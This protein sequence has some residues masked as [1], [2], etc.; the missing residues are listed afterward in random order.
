[1]TNLNILFEKFLDEAVYSLRLREETIKGYKAAYELLIKIMPHITMPQHITEENMI[2]FF[3]LLNSRE[4]I[5]GRNTVKKGIRRSTVA[6][7]RSK[8]N[9]FFKWL[10]RK[11]YISLNPFDEMEYPRVE[12]NN[13]QYLEKE[14]IEALFNYINYYSEYNN[15]LRKRNLAIISLALYSGL[16][17]GEVLNLKLADIDFIRKTIYVCG[18]TSKSKT[19]RYVLM[20]KELAS[21]LSD[22]INERTQ[23]GYKNEY[24]IVSAIKDTKFTAHGFKHFIAK[25]NQ[26]SG[27]KFHFHQ[28]RH[29]F[30]VNCIKNGFDISELQPQMGHKDIRMTGTYLRK[31][32]TDRMRGNIE[33]LR[34]GNW[35]FSPAQFL[36]YI[37]K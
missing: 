5:V 6:T 37:G 1:M 19:D 36:N 14:K 24:F 33:G 18:E 27:V 35:C 15:F 3:K 23:M 2:Q 7:Y 16:R 21:L 12:Y 17:K 25:L 32:P 34:N 10:R 13:Q 30:A 9:K 28:L 22:Y 11:N 4:R 31:M 26:E 29:T 20:N 8:L